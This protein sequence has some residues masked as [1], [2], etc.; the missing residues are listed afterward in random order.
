M[1]QEAIDEAGN[2]FIVDGFDANGNAINPRPKPKGPTQGGAFIPTRPKPETPKTTYRVLTP[3]EAQA[4]GLPPGSYKVSSE[5]EVVKIAGPDP[6]A[7][8]STPDVTAKIRSDAL[9]QFNGARM[10]NQAQSTMVDAFKK[11][12]GKTSGLSGLAD[13]L[14]GVVS[15]RNQNFNRDAEAGRGMVVQGLGLT[16]GSVNSMAEA[17]MWTGPYTPSASDWDS[18]T[19]Q[20]IDRI[21]PLRESAARDSI[22]VLGGVPDLD[23]T[24]HP[25]GSPRAN[26]ILASIGLT[27]DLKASPNVWDQPEAERT[28][29]QGAEGSVLN[30]ITGNTRTRFERS[31]QLEKA[32]AAAFRRG[33]SLEELNA[34]TTGAGYDPV[35]PATYYPAAEA[36]DK[37]LKPDVSFTV[38][39][40][41]PL[42]RMEELSGSSTGRVGIGLGNAGSFGLVKGMAPEQY[43]QAESMSSGELGAGEVLGSIAG[44]SM[45]G[46]LGQGVAGRLG[47]LGQRMLGGG[48]AGTFGRNLGTDVAY[49]GAYGAGS[50]DGVGQ[51]M[52]AG[53]IGSAF[54][55]GLGRVAGGALGGLSRA[56]GAR[57]LSAAGVP[58]TT[59]QQL[60]GMAKSFEDRLTSVPM[61]GDMVNARRTE[62][63]EGLQRTLQNDAGA[64]IGA[65]FDG[66][67]WREGLP[68]EFGN[69][70]DDATAG[71]NV[72]LDA[73]FM[74]DLARA[75]AAGQQLPPDLSERFNR[76]M[77]NRVDPIATGSSGPV[78]SLPMPSQL[79]KPTTP[80]AEQ[81]AR[82]GRVD[83]IPLST[84]RA[85]Q[86]KM[87]WNEQNAGQFAEPLIPGYADRPI[88]VRMQNGENI[89]Y[90]GN[91]RTV[92]ALND[93][94]QNM[95]M[96]SIDGS[97]Y[98]AANAGRRPAAYNRSDIDELVNALGGIDSAGPSAPMPSPAREFPSMT[99]E[100]YQQG[101]RGL[102][103]YK[104]EMTK[105]GF[106]QDYRGA[107]SGAQDVLKNQMMR[108]GGDQVVEGLAKADKAYRM[109][110][111]IQD[112]QT[113]A[114]GGSLS[115]IPG[116][117]APSQFLAAST[118]NAKKFDGKRP[119]GQIL[120]Q[121]QQIMPSK[122][123]NSGSADRLAQMAL[124]AALVG[125]TGAGYAT[126]GGE[127][128]ASG[129][130]PSLAIA[131]LLAM[132]GTKTGQKAISKLLF[133][134]P[135]AL[136]GVK[137]RR[138]VRKLQGLFGSAAVP[139]A[140]E[141]GN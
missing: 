39:R 51:S 53:G 62:G 42:S 73:Q 72:P 19:R 117:P 26:Q 10:L 127:G 13:F 38:G 56:P 82:F 116:L 20:G 75:R 30:A 100:T 93:G 86:S 98:D 79:N 68:Q 6:D 113:R 80:T 91:H 67:D 119:F 22:S 122:I 101:M 5:G 110:K 57:Q 76:A 89:I 32:I 95:D 132:G 77:A 48:K 23:G 134:R 52:V 88:A 140:L 46:K 129:A 124:P 37:G 33:A 96:Y 45:I 102:S 115:G 126:G 63:F 8:G 112:A 50:G 125:G 70:Y 44:T 130:A 16:G 137:G 4:Q 118:A 123:G 136:K 47:P 85:G 27:P 12:P 28:A 139:L 64:P 83:S 138:A 11:G 17:Q 55:Q 58:L 7:P 61:V 35:D 71:V 15:E 43:A 25:I 41:V 81:M 2:V 128:A 29:N 92:R 105:P 141:S 31:P 97:A 1:A 108:G 65:K 40:Q 87:A 14:P 120:D 114:A 66:G 109:A 99:G 78:S 135:A 9:G 60:G 107:L 121:A 36:R 103:G 94:R 133:D 111:V 84:A 54:G 59:G 24:I 3:E 21:A 106:E 49:S 104:A 34:I 90:D 69:A 18:T 131:G 74:D